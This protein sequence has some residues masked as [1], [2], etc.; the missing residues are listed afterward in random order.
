MWYGETNFSGTGALHDYAISAIFKNVGS[1][2]RIENEKIILKT[3]TFFFQ[4]SK[5]NESF[6]QFIILIA[7][8]INNKHRSY[9]CRPP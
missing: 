4:K 6:N 9:I 1:S 2:D 3:F 5:S 8:L 7:T